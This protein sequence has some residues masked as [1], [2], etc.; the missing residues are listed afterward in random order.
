MGVPMSGVQC[1]EWNLSGSDD[2]FDEKKKFW[3]S[4]LR[5]PEGRTLCLILPDFERGKEGARALHTQ[6]NQQTKRCALQV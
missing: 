4:S 5:E 3:K 2:T 6:R 1:S